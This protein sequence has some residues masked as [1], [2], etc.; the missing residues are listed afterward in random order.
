VC[1]KGSTQTNGVLKEEGKGKW[2][3][4][5]AYHLNVTC[6]PHSFMKE[7]REKGLDLGNY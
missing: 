1:A 4:K 7:R 6:S 2:A 3:G 5:L